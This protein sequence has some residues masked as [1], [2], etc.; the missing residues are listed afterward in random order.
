MK[1]TIYTIIYVFLVV[2][3]S[4]LKV[5]S[6]P[7]IRKPIEV[8]QPDGT[9][10]TLLLS[11]DEYLHI[12][13]T[14][15]GYDLKQNEAG[16][17]TY[18][19]RDAEGK[20]I[21]SDRIARNLADRS[22]S[23]ATYLRTIRS[24]VKFSGTVL[25]KALQKRMSARL[26]GSTFLRSSSSIPAG[27]I[28]DYPRTGSP[29][30]LVIL[31]NFLD[32]SFQT[33]NNSSAF[34]DM[35]NKP[36]YNVNKHVG[37]VKD[38]YKYN[39]GGLFDPNFV[40]VGP[41]IVPHSESYYG[42]NDSL[43]NDKR[44]AQM[45]YDACV[46]AADLVDFA[47]FDADVNGTV[48]NIFIYYAG[49][50]EADGGGENTI[51]PHSFS[52]SNAGLNLTL[53]GKKID[54]YACSSELDGFTGKMTGIGGFTHEYSHILGLADMYDVDY[55]QYNGQGFDLNYW[56][57]MAW[58][59]YNNESC[60]PPCLSLP[61]RYLLGWATPTELDPSQTVTLSDFG[62]TNNG[63]M[64]KT[65]NDGEYFLLENRQQT[66]NV[67][68]AYLPYHGLLIYHLDLRTDQTLL[69]NYWG[70]TYSFRPSEM[71][72]YNV[73]NAVANHQCCDLEEADNQ[74][75]F[76]TGSNET[77]YLNNLK[78]D[79]FPGTAGITQF[80][81]YSLPSMKSWSGAN[82]T[83][84]ITAITE[85]NGEIQ[86]KFKDFSGFNK[87]PTILAATEVW[88]YSF[89]AL[90]NSVNNA[91]GYFI[92]VFTLDKSKN[93]YEKV[94][95]SDYQSRLVTDT[96]LSVVVPDDLT[97]YY[98]QV[99]ATINN[100]LFTV[101][102]DSMSVTTTDGKPVALPAT[103]IEP[104]TFKANWNSPQYATGFYLDV[105]SI[106]ETTNDTSWTAGYHNLFLTKN[107][108]TIREL[109]DQT[110]YRYRVRATNGITISRSSDEMRLTTAKASGI[111]AYVSDRVL[112]LKGMDKGG[113][114]LIHS[115]DGKL[116]LTSFSN[117]I[118]LGR[119]GIYLI[120]AS[121]NG[122]LKQLKLLVP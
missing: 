43:G 5:H 97:T 91:T 53:D 66:K 100:Q 25:N 51:W 115:L 23:D 30:S 21:S 46:K 69:V 22:D 90:W 32:I 16:F 119:P 20:L 36:G 44:P 86:F 19:T 68:D 48:D 77:S 94:F 11:G 101:L 75:L 35:L 57:L 42:A 64:I 40:V 39:S 58:G 78:G 41:V 74:R 117:R 105:F 65:D 87:S 89:T 3:G 31:V 114:V 102:S 47:E 120:T 24:D 110:S 103:L 79:P 14:E 60:T 29:K 92:D 17:Y 72:R 71:W 104:F 98:Y 15:D 84:P 4:V 113:K 96:A 18:A 108:Q 93:P 28:A 37:S 7:A 6:I 10:L 63:C 34:N 82:L 55:N 27:L 99:R 8:I 52:L 109:D 81:D 73:V 107:F 76:R 26:K 49:K 61:E 33:N 67:W 83:K 62:S 116:V 59:S 95:L 1:R 56:S 80:T 45:V 85:S 12:A 54:D 50:G 112:N 9:K 111:L 38:Y 122:K 2:F 106:D 121:F 118:Y 70:T 13:Q 88:P